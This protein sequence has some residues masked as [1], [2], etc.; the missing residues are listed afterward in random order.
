[1]LVVYGWSTTEFSSSRPK[2][3]KC[4]NCGA[5]G[6]T[7]VK[8]YVK[9]WHLFFLPIF[10]IG[11]KRGVECVHCRHSAEFKEMNSKSNKNYQKYKAVK[12][13]PFWHFS[14]L[15]IIV[16]VLIWNW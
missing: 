10:P 14:G 12:V 11:V 6:K 15:F 13:P 16:T 9:T 2:T 7:F 5:I 3:I 8:H 4:H 1:M